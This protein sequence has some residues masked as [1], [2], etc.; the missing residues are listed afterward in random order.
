M[1]ERGVRVER[2][3]VRMRVSVS[4]KAITKEDRGVTMP[5]QTNNTIAGCNQNGEVEVRRARMRAQSSE[6]I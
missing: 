2:V 3:R 1:S 4:Q 5:G 6:H